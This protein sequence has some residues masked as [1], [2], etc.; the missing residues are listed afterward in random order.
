M[1]AEYR[2]RA[3]PSFIDCNAP[4]CP[5]ETVYPS[6]RVRLAG[7]SECVATKRTR[8]KL[9]KGLKFHG[10]FAREFQ[11]YERMGGFQKLESNG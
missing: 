7:E 10:L 6:G 11:G 5:L 1:K 3:C 9:G 4:V 8:Y 2:M